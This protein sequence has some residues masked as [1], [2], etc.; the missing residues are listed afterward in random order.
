MKNK[1]I[2]L[3]TTFALGL[4]LTPLTY[5][6]NNHKF[7]IEQ[8]SKQGKDV[9]FTVKVT[10]LGEAVDGASVSIVKDGKTLTSS[11]TASNGKASIKLS[12]YTNE[13]T[14][15]KIEKEGFKTQLLTGFILLDGSDYKFAMVKGSGTISTAVASDVAAIDRKGEDAVTKQKE[16]EAKAKQQAEKAQKKAEDSKEDA[17]DYAE[18]AKQEEQ[19]MKEIEEAAAAKRSAAEEKAKEAEAL[20]KQLESKESRAASRE[21]EAEAREK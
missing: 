6:A 9:K 16:K 17:A 21:E 18:K 3:L 5:A 14:T 4:S 12:N 19:R 20:E 2:V 10:Y 7:I 13:A 8:V 15:L 1:N 11:T